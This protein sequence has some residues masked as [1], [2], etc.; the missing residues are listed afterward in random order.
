MTRSPPD[1]RGLPGYDRRVA[2]VTP[3][4]YATAAGAGFN[5]ENSPTAWGYEI[6]TA[7]WNGIGP[8][9]DPMPGVQKLRWDPRR[10][11]LDVVWA[12]DAVALNNIL[13]Y[14]DGS[15]L[16]YGTGLAVG[17]DVYHFYALDWATGRVVLDL[18]LGDGD[19][20]IDGGN[21]LTV[22]ADRSLVYGSGDAGLVHITAGRPTDPQPSPDAEV[23]RL[24][25][26]PNPARG[27]IRVVFEIDRPGQVELTLR[28]ARGRQV[29]VIA[30]GTYGTGRQVAT[31]SH[32]RAPLRDL[33]RALADGPAVHGPAVRSRP[34]APRPARA[35]PRWRG[36]SASGGAGGGPVRGRR[37]RTRRRTGRQNRTPSTSRPSWK[38]SVSRTVA[39]AL[40]AAADTW[41]P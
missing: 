6:A 28:D 1:W 10:R 27:Q 18:P 26:V 5:T 36:A 39:P 21:Q 31:T 3:L 7:Q 25:V 32:G 19:E 2:A 24:R 9:R 38:S 29:A 37:G 20:F 34:V 8:K 4:P 35:P 30:D 13:T 11:S 33:H 16:V 41:A 40:R 15:K 14:S 22:L 23:S 17:T 12:T